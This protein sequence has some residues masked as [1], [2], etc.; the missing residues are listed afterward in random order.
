MGV[1]PPDAVPDVDTTRDVRGRR[2]Q[3]DRRRLPGLRRPSPHPTP[4]TAEQATVDTNADG[5]IST[6]EAAH[7][8]RTGG[9]NCNHGG[10]VSWIA[11]QKH[12]CADR[13]DR[14]RADRRLDGRR[15]HGA[16][17][18]DGRPRRDHRH[19]T[20]SPTPDPEACDESADETVRRFGQERT[21]RRQRL[22]DLAAKAERTLRPRSGEGRARGRE[23]GGARP[24]VTAAKA[25]ATGRSACRQGRQGQEQEPLTPGSA[26]DRLD[27]RHR[28]SGAASSCP[29]CCRDGKLSVQRSVDPPQRPAVG[30]AAAIPGRRQDGVPGR[31]NRPIAAHRRGPGPSQMTVRDQARPH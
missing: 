24:T 29:Q 22:P 21:T 9:K 17:G 16:R 25:A 26:R 19:R 6:T 20:P 10:Y 13:A 30:Y 18:S 3:R 14:E 1:T 8:A 2:R 23:G 4:V 11:H 15:R 31:E 5:V 12:D 27:E 28:A 7:S